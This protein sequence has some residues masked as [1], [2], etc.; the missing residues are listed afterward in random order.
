E[1]LL[2]ASQD[3][4]GKVLAE[5]ALEQLLGVPDAGELQPPR[6][7]ADE[8]D[9][10]VIEKWRPK[11]ESRSH[12]CPVGGHE[13]L[14]RQVVLA[15]AIDGSIDGGH[16]RAR[17]DDLAHVGV[18]ILRLRQLAKRVGKQRGETMWRESPEKCLVPCVRSVGN[19]VEEFEERLHVRLIRR[20]EDTAPGE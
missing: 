1:A 20:G 15:V 2:L 8:L 12:A 18:R 10:R 11:L 14:S 9:E 7:A 16:C 4:C 6:N 19:G 3:G 5:G 13:A 17:T